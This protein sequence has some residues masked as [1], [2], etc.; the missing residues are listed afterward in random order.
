MVEIAERSGGRA[1]AI[2]VG[3]TAMRRSVSDHMEARV[4][5]MPLASDPIHMPSTC[6]ILVSSRLSLEVR[7]M[8]D[9]M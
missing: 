3:A 4:M 6:C 7:V 9:C 5:T 8:S 2:W 1:L